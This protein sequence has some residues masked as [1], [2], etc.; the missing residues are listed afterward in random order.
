MLRRC[1]NALDLPPTIARATRMPSAT[2]ADSSTRRSDRARARRNRQADA[3]TVSSETAP[4]H[5]ASA[6]RVVAPGLDRASCA[7]AQSSAALLP[8][9][10]RGICATAQSYPRGPLGAPLDFALCERCHRGTSRKE[11]RGANW[12]KT[13]SVLRQISWSFVPTPYHAQRETVEQLRDALGYLQMENRTRG[14]LVPSRSIRYCIDKFSPYNYLLI[15][16]L[17]QCNAN[18]NK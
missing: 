4:F 9:K 1:R 6:R 15:E 13:G 3:P 5:A 7:R 8:P 18:T 12:Y 11:R 14:Y 2:L 10:N 16:I 17:C